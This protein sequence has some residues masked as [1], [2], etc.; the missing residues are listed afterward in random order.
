MNNIIWSVVFLVLSILPWALVYLMIRNSLVGKF[1][2]RLIDLSYIWSRNCDS[3]KQE[4]WAFSWFYESLPYHEKMM[5]SFK[6]LKLKNWCTQE[7]LDKLLADEETKQKA[8]EFG[9]I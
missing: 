3:N 2:I 8:I 7:Q 5:F 4:D 1:R 6:P 9:L